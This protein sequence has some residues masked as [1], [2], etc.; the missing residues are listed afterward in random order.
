MQTPL[1]I[2]AVLVIVITYGV[3]LN[4][5]RTGRYELL[6]WRNIFLMGFAQFYGFGTY[7]TFSHG[8]GS[9]VYVA[10]SEGQLKLFVAIPLFLTTL[11]ISLRV[12]G[13]WRGFGKMIPK[14][15][16]PI[17]DAGIL[18]ASV[19]VIAAALAMSVLPMGSYIAL[20]IVQFKVGLAGT[21]AAL[22]TYYLIA[23]RFNP[24][25]WGLFIAVMGAAGLVAM[26]GEVGRRGLLGVMMAVAWMW[27]YY[28]LKHNKFG[29]K[30]LKLG[31][32]GAGIFTLVLFY[33]SFRGEAS[34]G[35][36]GFSLSTRLQQVQR[37]A[38]NPFVQRGSLLNM[39]GSDAPSDT[40]Y[41]MERYPQSYPYEYLHGARFFLTNPIPRSIWADKPEGL[42][43]MVQNQV[44]TAA[45]LG[46]GFLGHGWA[47]GGF[48]GIM[49]Y[50]VFF[51]L[52][53]G[54][55][56]RLI[57]ERSWNPYFVAAIGANL[58]NVFGLPRGETSLFLLNVVAGFVGTTGVLVAIR[59]VLGPFMATGRPLLTA[60]NQ[61]ILEPEPT[62]EHIEN[63]F[64]GEYDA[65]AYG[66]DSNPE[67][68]SR[69]A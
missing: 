26:V 25:A 36:G 48:L 51:G 27:W 56:D 39:I 68:I 52:L 37:F 19:A 6:S 31:A 46:V 10:G 16:L 2:M 14:L 47:E 21:A 17:T 43:K 29:S 11:I 18:A 28:S 32:I 59:M 40:M 35:D 22:A 30:V 24:I 58:G 8:F 33:A 3:F 20:V 50:G 5:L 67:P 41:I 65:A 13:R 55:M 42:G 66:Y 53:I 69:S 12:G 49:S 15:Q 62:E 1:M 45:N 54:A 44:G 23:R 34:G 7:L 57:R 9:D 60:G 61:W 4:N 38:R 64:A 63:E